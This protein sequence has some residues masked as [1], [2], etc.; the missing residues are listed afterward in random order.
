MKLFS[1]NLLFDIM[2]SVSPPFI[3]RYRTG[4]QISQYLSSATKRDSCFSLYNILYKRYVTNIGVEKL[5]ECF[6]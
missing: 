1:F 5:Q 6:P 2:W 3:R 4:A